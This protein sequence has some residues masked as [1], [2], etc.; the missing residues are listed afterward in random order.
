MS[1]I[2]NAPD[3][4]LYAVLVNKIDGSAVTAGATLEIAKDGTA[5]AVADA[6]LT[7]R[8]G[9]LWEAALSQEDSNGRH[10]RPPSFNRLVDSLGHRRR[11]GSPARGR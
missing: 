2:K 9:G 7:H 4:F 11:R 10:Q 6:I 3:Q 1:L 5:S 8:A